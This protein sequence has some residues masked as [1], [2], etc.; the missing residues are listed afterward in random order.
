MSINLESLE[1]LTQNHGDLVSFMEL[2][3]RQHF[4]LFLF[5]FF[6]MVIS[7]FRFSTP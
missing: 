5:F 3:L 4:H 2:I 6:L 1:E 7:L